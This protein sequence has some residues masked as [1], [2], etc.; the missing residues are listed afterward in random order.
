MPSFAAR[1]LLP[2]I[3]RFLRRHPEIDVEIAASL[4]LVDFAR[5]DVDVAIRFGNGGW[6]G[7]IAERVLDDWFFPVASPHFRRG[8]LPKRPADLARLPLLRS[9][10]EYWRPWFVAAGLDLPEPVRG[11]GFNDS[12]LM[13]EAAIAGE[14]I[15][16]AR[17]SLVAG[18]LRERRLVRLFDVAVPSPHAYY[19]VHP[20][21]LDGTPKLAAFRDWLGEEIA[22]F[23]SAAGAGRKAAPRPRKETDGPDGSRARNHPRQPGKEAAGPDR[24]RRRPAGED[25]AGPRDTITGFV[26]G[27]AA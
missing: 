18:D 24:D 2:R 6:P 3:G 23:R 14:G 4:A 20:K 17:H 25:G 7:V 21:R 16:L 10:D 15:A 11:H 9:D 13:L 1:W 22:A 19:L 26:P 12:S 5:E 27:S 8:R